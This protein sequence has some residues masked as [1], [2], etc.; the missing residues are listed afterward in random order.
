[1]WKKRCRDL[2][3]AS[4]ELARKNPTQVV[5]QVGDLVQGDC[6]DA[7]THLKMLSDARSFVSGTYPPSM[8]FWTVMGNHDVRGK[9]A[10]EAYA[11]FAQ[12]LMRP[13]IGKNM[14]YPV[15][16]FDY[17]RD[18]WIFCD[19]ETRDIEA[20]I[21]ELDRKTRARYTFL[22]T[23]SPV[24]AIDSK[25]YW[26]R[27]AGEKFCDEATRKRLLQALSRR[28]AIVL[29]GHSHSVR[30]CRY[31]CAD[32]YFHEFTANSVWGIPDFFTT[33]PIIN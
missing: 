25:A 12:K 6:D 22:V 19:F 31:A 32:G 10:R 26:W 27:L 5:L 33:K 8:Q 15:T 11:K 29:T 24:I 17:G 30:F 16:A 7:A 1:M 23:H 20:L 21:K 14:Q 4:A 18:R 28:H 2:V 13:Q 9:D 3:A